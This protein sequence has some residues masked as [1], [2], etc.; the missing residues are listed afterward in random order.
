MPEMKRE[1]ITVNLLPKDAK[2]IRK[3]AAVNRRTHSEQIAIVVEDFNK[4][5]DENGARVIGCPIVLSK[6][7]REKIALMEDVL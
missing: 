2:K 1:R 4:Q 6:K 5:H 7:N 3:I